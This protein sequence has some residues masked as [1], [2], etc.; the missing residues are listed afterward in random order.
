MRG[1]GLRRTYRLVLR[2]DERNRI[3]RA[4]E[5]HAELD[6]SAGAAPTIATLRWQTTYGINF[7]Q[8][9]HGRVFGLQIRNGQPTLDLSYAYTFSLRELKNPIIDLVADAGW[10][11]RPVITFFPS[12]V[13]L[14]V[15]RV[16]RLTRP[17]IR[18]IG[19]DHK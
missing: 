11:F 4:V 9:Q 17:T 16:D 10:Q 15:T 5:R 3:V 8:Y 18:H 13:D 7:F 14:L 19:P 12:V 1:H 2:L 6:W